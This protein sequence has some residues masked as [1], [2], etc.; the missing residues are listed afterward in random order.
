MLRFA[1]FTPASFWRAFFVFANTG[2]A[3]A[4]L[5]AQNAP[6]TA[7]EAG[8]VLQQFREAGI[9]GQ[10]YLDFELQALPRRGEE[11][12]FAGRMWGGRNAQGAITRVEL[13][14]G[15][16]KKHRLLVQNGEKAAVWRWAG[17][18]VEGLGVADLFK[19]VIPGVELTAFDLQMPF[20]YWPDA[21]LQGVDRVRG[22]AANTFVF[23]A[24]A[25][26]SAQH[27]QVA[28]VRA[29]LDAQFHALVQTEL[30]DKNNRVLK[31]FS[32][33]S[34]KTING[35]VVPKAIDFRNEAT[36][37]KARLQTNAVGLRLDLSPGVFEPASLGQEIRPPAAEQLVPVN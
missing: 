35:Q 3:V 25:A 5:A 21:T 10:Y 15:S 7:A 4:D 8:K 37:D 1:L 19:P 13:T 6:L 16:G 27:P 18:K 36:G 17:D 30:L 20:I 2:P 23:K 32:P 31:R 33:L 26:F 11:Q 29:S 12:V 28:A 22:R 24:P 9:P 34:L 14:D